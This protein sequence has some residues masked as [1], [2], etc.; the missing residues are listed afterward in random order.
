MVIG[1]TGD[2]DQ[3]H[4]DEDCPHLSGTAREIPETKALKWGYDYCLECV[5]VFPDRDDP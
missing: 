1:Y 4:G 3:F 2:D 5:A